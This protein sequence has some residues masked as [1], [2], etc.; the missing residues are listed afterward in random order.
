MV[1][2]CALHGRALK[3]IED[4]R[5]HLVAVEVLGDASIEL[6]L[7]DLPMPDEVPRPRRE[8]SERDDAI[9]FPGK[10]HIARD[11]FPHKAGQ[12]FVFIKAA[13]HIVAIR[14]GVVPRLVLVIAVRLRVAHQVQP[15]LR[16]LLAKGGRV[17]QPIDDHFPIPILEE[18]LHLLRRRRQPGQVIGQSADQSAGRRFPHGGQAFLREFGLHEL[19]HRICPGL[20]PLLRSG[21][22]QGLQGPPVE[23]ALRIVNEDATLRPLGARGDPVAQHGDVSRREGFILLRH[24]GL[25]TAHHLDQQTRLGVA[26][27]D[28][29]IKAEG[30]SAGGQVEFPLR[31]VRVVAEEAFLLQNWHHVPCEIGRCHERRCREG[32]Q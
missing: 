22:A 11:L 12:R 3:D 20:P 25:R 21:R 7:A 28:V 24:V 13:D 27:N 2:L 10:Q 4:R 17:Q 29:A 8:K 32:K 9:R 19:I 6:R 14:P 26:G 18:G 1:A 31:L 23:P 15:M 16:E 30:R 5:D